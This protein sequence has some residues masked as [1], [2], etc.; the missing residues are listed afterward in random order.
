MACMNN[1]K[2]KHSSI[3]IHFA[4]YRTYPHS[5]LPQS[6]CEGRMQSRTVL[7]LWANEFSSGPTLGTDVFKISHEKKI[8]HMCNLLI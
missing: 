2:L 1:S 6:E 3:I 5:F 7:A 4:V 8:E